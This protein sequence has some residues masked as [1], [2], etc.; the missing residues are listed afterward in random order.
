ML[1]NYTSA[2]KI[3]FQSPNLVL[4]V[5]KALGLGLLT[6]ALIGTVAQATEIEKIVITAQHRTQNIQEVPIAVTSIDATGTE[7]ENFSECQG[8]GG[9]LRL[10][11]ESF[12]T[13]DDWN[14][15]SPKVIDH[16]KTTIFSETRMFAS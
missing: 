8:V 5:K 1:V 7:F 11:A 6:Y 15:L 4:A 14:D 9:S 3:F 2:D 10:I 13:S 16:M 12:T